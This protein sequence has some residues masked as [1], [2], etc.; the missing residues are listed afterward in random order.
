MISPE[1]R[2]YVAVD[3]A[4]AFGPASGRAL[5]LDDETGRDIGSE[6]LLEIVFDGNKPVRNGDQFGIGMKK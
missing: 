6:K 3:D 1:R 2:G 4:D 5:Q